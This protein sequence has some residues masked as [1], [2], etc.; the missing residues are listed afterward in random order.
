MGAGLNP[1]RLYGRNT[2]HSSKPAA[3]RRT[4]LRDTPSRRRNRP[5]DRSPRPRASTARGGSTST[6]ARPTDPPTLRH[7]RTADPRT[8]T[9]VSAHASRTPEHRKPLSRLGSA[10]RARPAGGPYS[11]CA[12]S[13]S[14]ARPAAHQLGAAA[15]RDGFC[16]ARAARRR[17]AVSTIDTVDT[18][19]ARGS[20]ACQ[21]DGP[22]RSST[23]ARVSPCIRSTPSAELGEARVHVLAQQ[24]RGPT[25]LRSRCLYS[26]RSGRSRAGS[27]RGAPSTWARCRRGSGRGRGGQMSLP[28]EMAPP[29]RDATV[30]SH[31][32]VSIPTLRRTGRGAVAGQ[33]ETQ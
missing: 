7:F 29:R 5:P 12:G 33:C 21:G 20:G 14:R 10:S 23:S 19:R 28:E 24:C 22:A 30:S 8:A 11:T 2:R 25:W 18:N 13:A 3:R 16:L 15:V 26:P 1:V 32:G 4:S 17:V 9:Y 27:L 6:N 31:E